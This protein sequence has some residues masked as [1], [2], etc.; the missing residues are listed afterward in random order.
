M[1][2]LPRGYSIYAKAE[3]KNR[4]YPMKKEIDF[5]FKTAVFLNRRFYI[6]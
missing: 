5:L 1:R 6:F 3:Y 2:D 4:Y